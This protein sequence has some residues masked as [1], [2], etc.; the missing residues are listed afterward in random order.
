MSQFSSIL[1]VLAIE[2]EVRTSKRTGKDYNH[3]AAR[4]VLRDEKGGVI[5]VGTLR[6]DQVMPELRDQMKVGLFAA[7]FSLRVPDFGDAKGD[8]V[9]MLTGFVPASGRVPQQPQAPKAS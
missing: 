7:T 4:C 1:E 9:S 6:S 3:F 5:T 2:N 8:I